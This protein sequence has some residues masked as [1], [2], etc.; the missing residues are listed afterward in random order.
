MTVEDERRAQARQRGRDYINGEA[1]EAAAEALGALREALEK[2]REANSDDDRAAAQ[3]RYL[4]AKA[5]LDY[6]I[7]APHV[8]RRRM[9]VEALDYPSGAPVDAGH[10]KQ[11]LTDCFFTLETQAGR[12]KLRRL[13]SRYI[14]DDEETLG[15]PAARLLVEKLSANSDGLLGAIDNVE[16]KSGVDATTGKDRNIRKSLV[17]AAGY[18]AGVEFGLNG[19]IPFAFWK[20]AQRRH[21]HLVEKARAHGDRIK[22]AKAATIKDWCLRDGP[23]ARI[24][25]LA[26]ADGFADR[27]KPDPSRELDREIFSGGDDLG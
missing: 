14:L 26:R 23:Y 19:N 11:V 8:R 20:R 4:E 24:F 22:A 5:V 2:E 12:D 18:S 7:E 25:G 13:L 10:F 16:G 6:E 21:S 1:G 15:R 3:A 27:D 17:M 9:A